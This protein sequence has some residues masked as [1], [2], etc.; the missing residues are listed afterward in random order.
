MKVSAGATDAWLAM[1]G[2]GDTG[3]PNGKPVDEWGIRVN[4]QDQ[5][6]GASV[7]RGGETNGPAAV[8]G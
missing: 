3:L 7:S 5:P 6:V 2:V 8:Y 1:A 4:E